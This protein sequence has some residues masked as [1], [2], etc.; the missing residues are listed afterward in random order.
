MKLLILDLDETLIYATEHAL[1]R[2]PDFMVE[3]YS[4]YIRPGFRQFIETV[5][6]DYQLAIWTSSNG[7]YAEQVVSQL[8]PDVSQLAFWWSRS[9]CSM[10]RDPE[11]DQYEWIKNLAKVKRRGYRLEQVLM[12]DD[13]PAKLAKHFGNL[14]RVL[15]FHGD[16]GDT[17]LVELARYL[18][19]LAHVENVRTCEKRY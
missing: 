7:A 13:T 15:P 8:F 10:R 5:A 6:Q 19:T 12:V 2:A 11:R 17:E 9:R 1:E 4:V 16:P 18:T 14:V 3:H